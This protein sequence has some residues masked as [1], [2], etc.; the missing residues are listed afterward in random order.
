MGYSRADTI[1]A[2]STPPDSYFFA[3][4]PATLMLALPCAIADAAT[5]L[6]L[7]AEWIGQYLP[8]IAFLVLLSV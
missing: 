5:L 7:H 3:D 2:T 8:L 6:L 4:Q 1:R